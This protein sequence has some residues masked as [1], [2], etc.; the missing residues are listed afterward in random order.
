MCL[1]CLWFQLSAAAQ[2]AIAS[3][4]ICQLAQPKR[5]SLPLTDPDK[6]TQLTSASSRIQLL[7]GE[8]STHT[9][10]YRHG[11]SQHAVHT[12]L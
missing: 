12:L 8:T 6:S 1:L 3:P 10:R 2:M 5:R 9:H 7:A 11:N 4:R